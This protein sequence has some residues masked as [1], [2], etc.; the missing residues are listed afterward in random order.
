MVAEGLR[1]LLDHEHAVGAFDEP[2]ACVGVAEHAVCGDM[3]ELSVRCRAGVVLA[4]RWRARGC[5][6]SMALAALAAEVLRDLPVERCAEVLRAAVVDRGGLAR[7]ERHA[8]SLVLRALHA[9]TEG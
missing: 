5:P 7:H 4:V 3:V 1:A 8:E 6:A 9:A 2:D